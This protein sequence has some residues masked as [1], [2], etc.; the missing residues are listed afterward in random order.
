MS[1]LISRFLFLK[2]SLQALPNSQHTGKIW[3]LSVALKKFVERHK[4]CIPRHED[5]DDLVRSLRN[6]TYDESG[7]IRKQDDH[8]A[9]AMI[10][11]ISYYDEV[12]NGGVGGSESVTGGTNLW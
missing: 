11:A 12:D 8:S 4:L 5:N 6:L 9:D 7:K 2:A 1:T 10:Y 3:N